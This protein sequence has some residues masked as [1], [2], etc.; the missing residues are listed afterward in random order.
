[1]GLKKKTES[2]TGKRASIDDNVEVGLNERNA[3]IDGK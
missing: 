2:E 1:L 3:K